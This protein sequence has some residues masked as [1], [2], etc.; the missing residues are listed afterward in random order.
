ML[1]YIILSISAWTA[2]VQ[3]TE[4]RMSERFAL[5]NARNVLDQIDEDEVKRVVHLAAY[6]SLYELNSHTMIH[7]VR[8]GGVDDEFS[9]INQ[10]MY[11][12]ITDGTAAEDNFV[13]GDDMILFSDSLIIW[14]K[15]LNNSLHE[16]G[17]RLT[18]FEASNFSI[19]QT[20]Q[21]AVDYTIQLRLGA[22]SREGRTRVEKTYAIYDSI[23]ITGFVDPAVFREGREAHSDL[24]ISKQFFFHSDYSIPET[25]LPQALMD[26]VAGQGWFYGKLV[27]TSDAHT[28]EQFNRSS[29]I[30]VGEHNQ[31]TS[32]RNA[33]VDF[34]HFGAYILTNDFERAPC[35]SE[36]E[37]FN[38][39]YYD[40][41]AG[42]DAS[43][44]ESVVSWTLKPFAVVPGFSLGN[45][46]T[47]PAPN[48][49]GTTTPAV[50]FIAEYDYVAISTEPGR[51][52]QQVQ[53]YNIENLRDFALCGYYTNSPD[54][55]S[56]LQRLLDNSYN[57][58]SE[59]GIESMLIGGF[60]GG[61]GEDVYTPSHLTSIISDERS[62][63]DRELFS[64][65]SGIKIRGMPGCKSKEMCSNPSPVGHFRLDNEGMTDYLDNTIHCEDGRA[66]C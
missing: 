33:E 60:I 62:R 52:N 19:N 49:D 42:C 22:E 48:R 56:Y 27:D 32:L 43:I 15:Q 13:S 54:A 3:V 31:I 35:M 58:N 61:G 7:P 6:N 41:E 34:E 37:T 24:N 44:Q 53:L 25:T 9:Y 1:G 40:P 10:T 30:L 63:L 38:P 59:L 55:P 66:E 51:K 57:R 28:I 20:S 12:L 4:Q 45:A 46:G 47:H 2:S 11:G 26:G 65:D 8:Y 64:G 14:S 50:L 5:K 23:D 21:D 16:I 36:S 17:Y 29:Y 18:I 39:I